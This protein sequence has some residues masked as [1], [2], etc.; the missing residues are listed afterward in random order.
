MSIIC[1]YCHEEAELVG[2]KTIYPHRFDL[3]HKA[4][5]RCEPC[6]AYVGCHPGTQKPL[7]ILA[8]E[9]LRRWKSKTHA[10]FDPIW[11]GNREM[12]RKQ[13]YSWLASELKIHKSQCHIGMFNIDMCKRVIN[14]CVK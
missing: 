13:A 11:R 6:G 9:I 12:S 7:G 5:W 14:L 3:H 2:G 8:D 10:A 1:Q 4:F